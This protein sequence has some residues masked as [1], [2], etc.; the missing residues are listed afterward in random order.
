M[1]DGLEGRRV[2]DAQ[3]GYGSVGC[4]GDVAIVV[5]LADREPQKER[6]PDLDDNGIDGD[7]APP[8]AG[9]WYE[10]G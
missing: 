2:G 3:L 8:L 6:G 5:E 9:C 10:T 7:R 1:G 4:I